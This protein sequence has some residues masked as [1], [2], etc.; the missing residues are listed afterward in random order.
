MMT[1]P[2]SFVVGDIP[3]PAAHYLDHTGDAWQQQ[4]TRVGCALIGPPGAGKT[5]LAATYAR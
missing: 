2:S 1:T 5:Q 3:D 4:V